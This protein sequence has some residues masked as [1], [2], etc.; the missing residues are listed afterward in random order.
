MSCVMVHAGHLLI[1]GHFLN[2]VLADIL[3]TV[4][5][6]APGG[7]AENAGRLKLLQDDAVIF[8]IDFQLVTLR[9]I[10]CAA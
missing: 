9:N 5:Q 8:H 3:S 7:A 6:Q 4:G 2:A 1:F 10:Q